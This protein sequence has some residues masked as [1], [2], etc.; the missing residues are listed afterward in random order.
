MKVKAALYVAVMGA[1]GDILTLFAI[2]V[3]PNTHINLYVLPAVLVGSTSGW[4]LG[5]LAGAIGGLYTIVLW[6]Q[7]YSIVY[8]FLLGSF[9][10]VF[11]QKA[12][13]RPFVSGI[14]AHILTLPWLYFSLVHLVGSP[15]PVFYLGMG[16][17]VLQLVAA[18]AI[19]EGIMA[20]PALKKRIL[21]VEITRRIGGFLGH[22]WAE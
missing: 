14:L 21:K 20:V 2:P 8:G 7:P 6:G 10:G 18:L 4:F 12:G 16:T 19:T 5:G 13:L 3:G 15:L 17:M 9:T 1:L 11:C 22:P